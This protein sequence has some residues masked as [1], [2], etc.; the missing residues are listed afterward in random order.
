MNLWSGDISRQNILFLFMP[1]RNQRDSQSEYGPLNT[2]QV[3]FT[4]TFI[5]FTDLMQEFFRN[6]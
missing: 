1:A 6:F 4:M 2:R 5:L 3:V